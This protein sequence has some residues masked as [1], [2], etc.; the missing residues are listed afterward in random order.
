MTYLQLANES[1]QETEESIQQE[2]KFYRFVFRILEPSGNRKKTEVPSD[3]H[4]AF[5]IWLLRLGNT[6]LRAFK[7]GEDRCREG[8]KRE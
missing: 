1:A 2:A 5:E 7:C 3:R 6:I 4:F 8:R